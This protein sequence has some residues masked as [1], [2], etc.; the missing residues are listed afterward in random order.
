MPWSR[1]E[2]M[3]ERTRFVV[4]CDRGVYTMTELCDRYGVSRKTGYKWRSRYEEEG[5]SGLQDRS[6]APKHCPHR[7]SEVVRQA[8]LE[9]KASH[10]S[11]GPRKLLGVLRKR[12]PDL[13]LPV[14]STVGD[15]LARE[16][17]VK[18][19]R[20]RRKH[21]H[22]GRPQRTT[23][24]ANDLWTSDYK[25]Q[26]KLG[27]GEYCYPLTVADEH[28]R[29]LIGCQALDSTKGQ[30]AFPVFKRLFREYGLPRAILTDNGTPFASTGLHGLTELNVWWMR[31]GIRHVRTEPSSPQQNGTHER[32][33]RTLKAEATRPPGANRGAQQRKFNRFIDEF[34]EERPHEALDDRTPGELYQ[35]S[36]RAYP[37]RLPQIEYPSHFEVRLV[38]NAGTIRWRSKQLFVSDPLRQ[39]YIG[40]EE[41]DD[42]IWSVY[43]SDVLLARLDDRERR[44]YP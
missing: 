23:E 11:W 39:N 35:P 33:H 25:G 3:K 2:P 30:E 40:L 43:F 10:P 42:G 24:G 34:N 8:L 36:E 21:V 12:R 41:V 31:L 26:F 16:G 38:S 13:D 6:R 4:D 32:M 37:Q 20:R 22:P 19:R 27:S 18:H 17:L 44:I 9:L 15:L 28:T 5:V 29:Y 1:T 14:R 7:V